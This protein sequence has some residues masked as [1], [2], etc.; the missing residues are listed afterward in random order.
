MFWLK[1]QV[2]DVVAKLQ[3]TAADF[4][5]E[6]GQTNGTLAHAFE[7]ALGHFTAAAGLHVITCEAALI[8]AR[9]AM[10]PLQP[11]VGSV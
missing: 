4:E 9:M 3:L 8:S 1:P 7:Y 11:T 10:E 6:A 2:V 5:P